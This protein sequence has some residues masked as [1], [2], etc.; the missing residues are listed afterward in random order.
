MYTLDSYMVDIPAIPKHQISVIY[1]YHPFLVSSVTRL[2]T[3]RKP[4]L[5]LALHL[6]DANRFLFN[7]PL[8][9]NLCLLKSRLTWFL[10]IKLPSM[11]I[12]LTISRPRLGSNSTV[13]PYTG[14]KRG[15]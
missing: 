10:A 13:R 14:F 8:S 15:N 4:F 12:P 2:V 7:P 11:P 5:N 3:S 1:V 9:W 6:S